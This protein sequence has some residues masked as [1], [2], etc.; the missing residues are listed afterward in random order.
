MIRMLEGFMGHE[1]FRQGVV[2]YLEAFKYKNAETKDLWSHLQK[3]SQGINI[4]RVMDTWI[5]QMG[6]PVLEVE[7]SGDTLTITQQ[8]FTADKDS[9]FNPQESP[10]K[11]VF[12]SS[13]HS[14]CCVFI[15]LY[16]FI[17]SIY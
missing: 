6:Y 7:Q 5:R 10:F 1:N 14:H 3:F 15:L 12:Q 9:T 13:P 16:Y 11:Y 17:Y 8:R 2:S 4:S